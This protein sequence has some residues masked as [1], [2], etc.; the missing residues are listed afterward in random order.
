M[1]HS[2]PAAS[3]ALK[4]RLDG[5]LRKAIPM[6]S[7]QQLLLVSQ[8]IRRS[9]HK[10]PELVSELL[11]FSERRRC[12]LTASE[13]HEIRRAL[14]VQDQVTRPLDKSGA[15][16]KGSVYQLHDIAD[17]LPGELEKLTQSRT[18]RPKAIAH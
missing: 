3:E 18:R 11:R 9:R 1:I 10:P 4:K 2:S 16:R 15:V 12:D 13:Y 14:G 7:Q 6:M 8:L 5:P 17:M